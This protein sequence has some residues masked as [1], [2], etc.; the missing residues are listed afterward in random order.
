MA[1]NTKTREPLQI[2]VTADA[3]SW[4]FEE[5]FRRRASGLS[6]RASVSEVVREAIDAMRSQVK[7]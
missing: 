1:Q 7:P 2:H 4:L 6:T 3:K 5:A